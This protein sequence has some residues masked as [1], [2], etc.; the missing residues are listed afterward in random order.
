[1]FDLSKLSPAEQGQRWQELARKAGEEQSKAV[2][3]IA[4]LLTPKQSAALGEVDLSNSVVSALASSRVQ[5]AVG[6]TADQKAQRKR[7][8]DDNYE[9]HDVARRAA[10]DKSLAVLTPA[11]KQK[12]REELD[13]R[14]W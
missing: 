10:I 8:N 6:L 14:G 7:I 9:R 1:M 2:Q 5:R 4:A 11:Q 12:L 13:R 3:E